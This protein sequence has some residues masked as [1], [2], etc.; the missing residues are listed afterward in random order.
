MIKLHD[1]NLT[2]GKLLM[3][4]ILIV[5]GRAKLGFITHEGLE[6]PSSTCDKRHID[7]DYSDLEDLFKKILGT[8]TNNME[9]THFYSYARANNRKNLEKL[10]YHPI[11]MS[12]VERFNLISKTHLK[13]MYG[14]PMSHNIHH[15]NKLFRNTIYWTATVD[16]YHDPTYKKVK[17]FPYR[18]P[19]NDTGKDQFDFAKNCIMHINERLSRK[20]Q[21]TDVRVERDLS[22]MFPDLFTRI[23]DFFDRESIE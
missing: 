11:L 8:M 19:Y 12:P 10:Y 7:T 18:T 3:K 1:Q 15:F 17:D 6:G 22:K 14:K 2:H 13:H 23:F 5:N 9:L 16:N 20:K 21:K 4:E